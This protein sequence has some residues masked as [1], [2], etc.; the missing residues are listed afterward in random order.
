MS[1]KVIVIVGPTA[2]GKSALAVNLATAINGEIISGDAFM[3]YKEMDIGT[4]KTTFEEQKE[5]PHHLI[6]ICNIDEEYSVFNFQRD[7]RQA[8]SEILAVGK[9]PIIAG[10]TGLYITSAIYDYEFSTTDSKRAETLIKFTSKSN[11]ELYNL[12]LLQD[13]VSAL[14][15]HPNNRQRL[16]S[17][18]ALIDETKEKK[19]EVL[20]RQSGRLIYDCII[21]GLSVPRDILIERINK[22]VDEMIEKGLINE[23][24]DLTQKYGKERNAFK[25]I[26]YKELIEINDIDEAIKKIKITTRQYAKRQM[27][28]F[29]NKMD[30]TWF[31]Y[32]KE[33]DIINYIRERM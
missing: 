33:K 30:V 12:L 14:K 4:A 22:R 2:S 7:C 20:E 25:A 3:V 5:I 16:L 11:E 29:R 15:V 28:W 32:N 23:V 8:I 18:L 26:G 31:D 13:E 21:I 1:N 9:T 24:Q 6:D 27:T 10:G 17:A 19:S